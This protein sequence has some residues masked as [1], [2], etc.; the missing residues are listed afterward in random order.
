MIGATI[1]IPQPSRLPEGETI[2]NVAENSWSTETST[3]SMYIKKSLAMYSLPLKSLTAASFEFSEQTAL[4]TKKNRFEHSET[5]S[6]CAESQEF[7]VRIVKTK[8]RKMK[9]RLFI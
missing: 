6:V 1:N 3:R 5:N 2:L 4:D 8:K 7:I 9:N